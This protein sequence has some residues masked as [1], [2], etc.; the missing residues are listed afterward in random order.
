MLNK[1]IFLIVYIFLNGIVVEKLKSCKTRGRY[2]LSSLE[3][4]LNIIIFRYNKIVRQM[5][6]KAFFENL[7][8]NIVD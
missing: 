1:Q 3:T 2:L 4:Y 5:V 6:L 7:N 8:Q